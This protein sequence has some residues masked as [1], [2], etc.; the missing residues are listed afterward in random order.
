MF[1][2]LALEGKKMTFYTTNKCVFSDT[3]A[4]QVMIIP[5]G[6]DYDAILDALIG[7]YG[8]EV[9]LIDSEH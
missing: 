3:T 8:P 6:Y 1:D 9:M 7:A 4:T 2:L 5:E